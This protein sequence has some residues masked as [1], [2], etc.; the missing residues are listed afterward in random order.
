MMQLS[1]SLLVKLGTYMGKKTS[2]KLFYDPETTVGTH[3]APPFQHEKAT[4][5]LMFIY[6]G[7]K[8]RVCGREKDLPGLAHLSGSPASQGGRL[9]HIPPPRRRPRVLSEPDLGVSKVEQQVQCL[10]YWGT[11]LRTF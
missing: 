7:S 8:I 6:T 10:L 4:P 9:S 1:P 11:V 2:Q 5:N 3:Q